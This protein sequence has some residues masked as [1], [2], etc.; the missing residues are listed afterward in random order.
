MI[1]AVKRKGFKN[2]IVKAIS[3]VSLI[4]MFTAYYFAGK[5]VDIAHL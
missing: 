2:N 5:H 1:V 3:F 4:I